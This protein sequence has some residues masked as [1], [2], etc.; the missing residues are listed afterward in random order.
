MG[1]KKSVVATRARSSDRRQTAA[2][3]PASVPT[4]DQDTEDGMDESDS[5]DDETAVF[6]TKIVGWFLRIR[7]LFQTLFFHALVRW[8]LWL[9]FTEF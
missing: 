2:S 3:S 1:V 8:F 4:S 9:I 7:C 6:R 5:D